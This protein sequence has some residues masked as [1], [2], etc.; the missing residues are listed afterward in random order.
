MHYISVCCFGL[1][2]LVKPFK[3]SFWVF[4]GDRGDRGFKGEKGDRGDRGEKT[5]ENQ[6]KTF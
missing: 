1:I 4:A 5:G 2:N 6:L 3:E